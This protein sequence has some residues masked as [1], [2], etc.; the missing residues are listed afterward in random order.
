MHMA[1]VAQ[2]SL[3]EPEQIDFDKY[4]DGGGGN[5]TPPAEGKYVGKA[6]VI[7]DDGTLNL[8]D[9]NDFTVTQEGYLSVRLDPIEL[10]DSSAKGYKVRFTKLSAKKYK[11]R[12][13]SQMLDFLRS[14]GIAARPK[15]NAELRAALKM[16]S[17]RTFTFGLQWE[18]YNKDTKERTRG[19]DNFPPNPQN[20]A[21][22][23]P[24]LVDEFDPTKKW[25]ANGQVRYFVSA[26]KG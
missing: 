25:Y 4:Q 26:V 23:L 17:G 24:Y 15:S 12:E 20:P 13:G 22:K 6:P 5:Y 7:K 8:S 9:T 10:L 11:N 2:V 1:D 19:W 16:A 3:I 18:A 14:C 21:E